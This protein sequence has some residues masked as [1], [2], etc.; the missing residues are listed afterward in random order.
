MFPFPQNQFAKS[1]YSCV[2]GGC[3]QKMVFDSHWKIPA[4]VNFEEDQLTFW[5]LWKESPVRSPGLAAPYFWGYSSSIYWLTLSLA[6]P[7]LTQPCLWT[8][9]YNLPNSPIGTC[10]ISIGQIRKERPREI[11]SLVLS[12][13]A[14]R[15]AGFCL[16]S[17]SPRKPSWF[18]WLPLWEKF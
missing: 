12:H 15:I 16:R 2:L 17:L 18:S 14:L 3:W 5:K 11:H 10:I 4:L 9:S 8:I 6:S 13:T 7:P 1:I